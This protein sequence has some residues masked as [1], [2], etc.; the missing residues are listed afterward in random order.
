[1]RNVPQVPTSAADMTSTLRNF[2]QKLAQLLK[3]TP[4]TRFYSEQRVVWN[5]PHDFSVPDGS[6][7]ARPSSPNVVRL[8]RAVD[9]EDSQTPVHFGATTWTWQGR[10]IVRVIDVAGL[11]VGGKYTLVW[12]VLS[13]V[14]GGEQTPASTPRV[15]HQ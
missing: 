12:E 11:R 3:A 9:L 14:Q 2:L 10:D 7:A 5:V 8:A 1:M 15:G 6:G 13:G 4:D